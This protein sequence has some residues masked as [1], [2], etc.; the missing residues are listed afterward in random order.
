MNV[1]DGMEGGLDADSLVLAESAVEP[2]VLSWP[3]GEEEDGEAEA[4]VLVAMRREGG[5]LLVL[6]QTFLPRQL[7]SEGNQGNLEGIFGPSQV[8]TVPAIIIEDEIVSPTGT[9]VDVMVI[10]CS[11]DVVKH[12]RAFT[13]QE[14]LVYNYDEDSPYALPSMDALLPKIRAWVSQAVDMRVGFYTPEEAEGAE[15]T[16]A[17]PRRRKPP[18]KATP[19]GGG[20][21]PK[22][23]TTATLATEMRGILDALPQITKQ[24]SVM[25]ERQTLLESRLAVVPTAKAAAAALGSTLSTSLPGPPPP[26]SDL[27]KSLQPPPR[28]QERASLGLLA[29]PGIAKQLEVEELAEERLEGLKGSSL[30]SDGA[31]AQAVL[32]QSKALTSLVA[33]IASS[34]ND[35]LSELT[36]SS[37]T[38]GT[39]GAATRSR[40][41]LELAQHKGL[42]FQSVLQSMSRR[43]APTSN[44][45]ATAME[46]LERGVSGVRYLERFGG[47]GRVK[48]LGQIQYQVMMIM[49]FLM[50]ENYLAAM[51]GVALL[52]VTLEQAA[53]DGGRMELATLLCL[54]EDPPASIF[55]NRQL[56]STSRARSFAPLADQ[57]WVTC[58]LAFLK[59]M[60]VISNKRNEMNAAGR[61]GFEASSE[62]AA[63]PKAKAKQQPKKKGRGKGALPAAEEVEG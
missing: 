58:A 5:I 30:S 44:P 48:E 16:P 22:R 47:Y 46:L 41:Q 3:L 51:D 45:S 63:A 13:Y 42:F 12:M 49:D 55:V 23:P 6:P 40:L 59:E 57:R 37:S 14:E 52:A 1:M 28:T 10:D 19:L 20:A 17:T 27:V 39:R 18:A 8:F 62:G 32:A 24:L 54:Q 50:A 53:L 34:Q 7:V 33:Q 21:K 11:I 26:V 29:S 43:M 35:P 31:L 56:S 15:E 36:G 4:T 60:E 38:A 61:V 2:Y 9:D 25:S